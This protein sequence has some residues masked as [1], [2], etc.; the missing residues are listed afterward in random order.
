MKY[1]S[2]GRRIAV[3]AVVALLTLSITATVQA[4]S[5]GL[6][7]NIPFEFYVGDKLL[8]AGT[9]TVMPHGTGGA[10]SVA[11]NAGHSAGRL[12]NG[13]MRSHAGSSAESVL[14]F[15]V[16]GD[17]YFLTEVRWSGYPAARGLL[18]S[19]VEL[20]VAKALPAG[21]EPLQEAIAAKK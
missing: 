8:P 2:V 5:T 9:Y 1:S 6:R 19:K 14:I 4:Q 16:Y 3:A 10:I 7:A 11:D 21:R 13:V 17:R 20:E 15:N 18:K 12:T